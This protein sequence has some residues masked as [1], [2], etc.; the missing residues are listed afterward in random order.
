MHLPYSRRVRQAQKSAFYAIW[1]WQE[2][3][4]VMQRITIPQLGDLHMLVS[5]RVSAHCVRFATRI[6]YGCYI[7][8]SHA[9]AE[10][11]CGRL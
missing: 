3:H 2:L 5:T 4:P 9:N 10:K 11:K 8:L 1:K 7:I 6:G